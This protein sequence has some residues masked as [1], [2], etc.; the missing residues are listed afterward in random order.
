MTPQAA[1]L[2]PEHAAEQA[3]IEKVHNAEEHARAR[4]QQAPEAGID[5]Y[6]SRKARE[7]MLERLEE[8]IDPEALC[9]GRIDLDTGPTY[10]LG[11][12]AVHG[13][14]NELLVINW[15]MPAA[16]PF[17]TASARD[18]Q[19]LA[20]RRR[21]RLDQL[22]LLGIV[23]DAFGDTRRALPRQR[24]PEPEV[25]GVVGA[26]PVDPHVADA[27]LA[28]MDRARGTEMR[29]IVATI[30]AQQ[31]ELIS[32]SIDGVLTIQG[33]PGSGKTAIALHRAAWLLYNH[34]EQL[35]RTGVLV[36]GP[37]RAFMEYVSQVLPTLGETA[38][39]QKAIDRLPDIG[40]VRVRGADAVEVA[41]LKGDIHM[42]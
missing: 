37:N 19:G 18:P 9:F 23:E 39:V 20:R 21:F 31:Y 34:Q 5:K 16:A 12:G 30:E 22:R 1:G 8:T 38:V 15:R 4:A 41:R 10:Y 2:H 17:Y 29:D 28:E 36:V 25:D 26:P 13:E 7:R 27:I 32:D 40:D 42:A 11:R 35:A 24:V 33:G 14:D 3:Y 6:S